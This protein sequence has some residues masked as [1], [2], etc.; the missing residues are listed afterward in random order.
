MRAVTRPEPSALLR[1]SFFIALLLAT[2]LTPTAAGI[3]N[4]EKEPLFCPA[5]G[6]SARTDPTITR[7]RPA[8]V[9]RELLEGLGV[10]D[11]V[12]LNLFDGVAWTA[13]FDR[14]PSGRTGARTWSGHL[15]G[16]E[17][18]Q[19]T[20][21]EW[22]EVFAGDIALP[23][24]AYQVRHDGHGVYAIHQVDQSAFPPEAEPISV[25]SS[26]QVAEARVA[27]PSADTGAVI[28]VLVV[29]TAEARQAAGGT[30]EMEAL[31]NLAVAEANASYTNS[32]ISQRLQLVYMDEVAYSEGELDW[33]LALDRLRTPADGYLDRVHTL[34]D[35]LCADNVVLLVADGTYCGLAYMMDS[36]ESSFESWAFSLV[37]LGCA[38][39]YY[40][41]AHEL[42]HNMA[43]H[44]D[45]YVNS[46]TLPFPHNHGYVQVEG[47]WRTIMSY[48]T[49]C[50]Y[51]GIYCARLPY[52]SNPDLLYGG[53]PMG[54]Y[55]GTSTLCVEGDPDHPDCDA[56]NRLVLNSTAAT[57]AN[58]RPSANCAGA[59]P[60]LYDDFLADDDEGGGSSGNGDGAVDCGETVELYVE[61]HNYGGQTASSPSATISAADPLVTWLDNTTSKYPAIPSGDSSVNSDD[62]DLVVSPDV[63]NG[64]VL[65]FDLDIGDSEG[66]FWTDSFDVPVTCCRPPGEPALTAPADGAAIRHPK[67]T[68]VWNEVP[69]AT[70]YRVEIALD[71]GF[72]DLV[73]SQT[74]L[75]P[76]YSPGSVLENATYYWRV[77]GRNTKD[78]CD[79]VGTTSDIWSVTISATKSYLPLVGK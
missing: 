1:L 30:A 57:V 71:P 23:G 65:T 50:D 55:P 9:N 78:G 48:N 76:R 40:S 34:R 56:D 31:I 28:D 41:F 16:V 27:A 17:H 18:S 79:I 54:V 6:Q 43:A 4:G 63:P 52:W 36:V 70:E 5:A 67:P 37:S 19:V 42:G 39:G 15:E 24:A 13:V 58:F 72:A 77:A 2:Q 46:S 20:L 22:K 69:D 73:A 60:L 44:H 51:H 75:S 74:V 21:V 47:G 29:Y 32:L 35:A 66:G 45:W 64:H 10:G 53:E 25:R 33:Y 38:T 7:T 49:E 3:E 26:P 59:G 68:F 61:L 8:T 62:F 12:M 11:A 14:V